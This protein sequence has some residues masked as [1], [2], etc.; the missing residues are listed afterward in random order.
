M[1]ESVISGLISPTWQH[2]HV[3]YSFHQELIPC[4]TITAHRRTHTASSYTVGPQAYHP[5]FFPSLSSG[6]NSFLL[7]VNELYTLSFGSSLANPSLGRGGARHSGCT[8][9]IPAARSL[10][11]VLYVRQGPCVC[12]REM[13]AER[14]QPRVGAEEGSRRT[15]RKRVVM[16]WSKECD[17]ERGQ[18]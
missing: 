1:L 16:Y 11:V 10:A 2:L 12:D 3:R 17:Y 13:S 8:V 18:T 7:R 5:T 14:F 4:N 15:R 9:A 6:T